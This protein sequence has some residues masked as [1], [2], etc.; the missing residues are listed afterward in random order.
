MAT[1]SMTDRYDLTLSGPERVAN[2]FRVEGCIWD[3][4]NNKPTA[5]RVHGEART[6]SAAQDQALEQ[7]WDRMPFET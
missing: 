5:V 7:A 1:F 4:E 3:R 6:I 2:G